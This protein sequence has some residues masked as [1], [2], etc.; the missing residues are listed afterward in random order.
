L[1]LEIAKR[2]TELHG[3]S[4]AIQSVPDEGTTVQVFLPLLR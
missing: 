3:G 4:L 2:I 1:G